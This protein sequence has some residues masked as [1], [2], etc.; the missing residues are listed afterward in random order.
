VVSSKTAVSVV[1]PTFNRAT[2]VPRAIDSALA[3]ISRGDEIIVVDDGSTDGTAEAVAAYGDPVR[4]VQL[5]HGGPG[6]AR[7]GGVAAATRPLVAFLDSDDEWFPD[8]LDLQ[9]AFLG[10]RPDVLFV[11]TD[12]AVRLEDGTEQRRHLPEWL[13]PPRPLADVFDPW[14]PFS[15]VA[16]PP[17]GRPDFLVHVGSIY[18]EQMHNN[19]VAA[20]TFIGRREGLLEKLHFAD[21]IPIC[22]D[23]HAFGAIADDGIAAIFDTETAWQNGHSGPR[24]TDYDLH[25]LASGWLKT[26]DRI[27]GQ[28]EEFLAEHRG[29]FDA[30]TTRAHLV[31]AKS[32]ARHGRLREA[33]HDLRAA[34]GLPAL[35]R[36]ARRDAR[37]RRRMR[38]AQP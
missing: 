37:S 24:V 13:L 27:C 2:I 17:E 19:L 25:L 12:F 28:D 5:P 11:F 10:A 15:S 22:E 36:T 31:R 26:L 33:G 16:P 14:I 23:R 20:F 4:F 29:E 18:R 9:R 38:D 1:I 6:A 8:K 3:A 7:N 21:D 34:G 30:A 35:V 32:P